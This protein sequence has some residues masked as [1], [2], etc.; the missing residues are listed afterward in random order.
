[1]PLIPRSARASI[2]PVQSMYH[3]TLAGNAYAAET[4]PAVCPCKM[5]ADGTV[6]IAAAADT[7]VGFTAID[8]LA[9]EPVTLFGA[10]ARAKYADGA[11]TPNTLLYV[12]AGG[13][14]DTTAAGDPVALA[15][16][17]NDILVMGVL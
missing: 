9:G 6:G 11:L 17:A 10:K 1:M 8:A 5:N 3:Q 7:V 16:S 4:I 15:I 13:V 14:L 12:G 2:D